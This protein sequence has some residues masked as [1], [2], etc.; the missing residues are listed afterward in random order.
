MVTELLVVEPPT[1]AQLVLNPILKVF[2]CESRRQPVYSV[3]HE[4]VMV[5]PEVDKTILVG[6]CGKAEATI[7]T[8]PS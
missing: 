5:L 6:V 3:G 1:I 4:S 7:V 2:V 8:V